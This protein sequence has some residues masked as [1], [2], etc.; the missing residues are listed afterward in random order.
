[1]TPTELDGLRIRLRDTLIDGE[2]WLRQIAAMDGAPEDWERTALDAAA[3]MLR[4]RTR[5]ASSLIKVAMLGAF[6]SGKSFLLSALQGGLE[7]VTVPD[8][9]G[10]P[11]EKFVGLLPSSPVPTTACPAT[12]VPVEPEDTA[13]DASQRGF[14]RVQ[15]TDSQ[16]DEWE[17]V[18]NS[19]APSVVAAYA[20]QDADPLE[21]LRQ[22]WDREVAEIEI[23]LSTYRLPAMLYDLPGAGSVN[24][25]HDTIIR[26]AMSKADCFI[27]VVHA[28]RSM[29]D[30]DL[31]LIRF[32]YAHHKISKK[33]VIWLVTAIDSATHLDHRNVRAWQA[34]VDRNNTYLKD[35]FTLD[36]RPDMGFINEGFIPVSP[37]SEARSIALEAQGNL[38]EARTK[39]AESRMDGLRA[40]LDDLISR[41]T[42]Q[43]HLARVAD[44]ASGL[45]D[46]RLNWL[47]DRLR[48]ERTPIEE[49]QGSL[50]A[51]ESELHKVRA[52]VP[53]LRTQL[54]E[55]LKEHTRRACRPFDRLAAHLHSVLDAQILATDVKRPTKANQVQLAKTQ[56]MQS[57]IEARPD[58][59]AALWERQEEHFKREIVRRVKEELGA[60]DRARQLH[61]HSFDIETLT[62]P[63]ARIERPAGRDLVQQTAALL[64]ISAP[65]VATG[66]WMA[67]MAAAGL[68]FPPA[69]AVL[70]LSMLVYMGVQRRRSRA[71]SLEVTQREWIA[72]LD[73]EA[74][75]V[76]ESFELS[77][78]LQGMDLIANLVERLESHQDELEG[79]MARLQ[80]RMAHPETQDQQALVDRLQAVVA[81]G[82]S[83]MAPLRA[84]GT[85]VGAAPRR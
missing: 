60:D 8:R 54:E 43:P 37:A 31:E 68:V 83:V 13:H 36:G 17:D 64:G 3:E 44:E 82:E 71:T 52:A 20:M 23:L 7:L 84:L 15:F 49:L 63:R 1:M 40:M 70:G 80:E 32:L 6:S 38:A 33:P 9:D 21:R 41:E 25:I 74:R 29:S 12:V 35:N 78:G 5:S 79:S 65:I 81:E 55:Q 10:I 76:R 72:A 69:I 77:I 2:S 67:G 39:A 46:H 19:P 47:S 66:S 22:H 16:D 11:A 4:L 30:D 85:A 14:L 50:S 24:A 58:G 75:E 27:Y 51:Q 61:G 48:M 26:Q 34:N 62:M 59:P 56:E 45:L 53:R 18:G 57:W 73:T 42:G 28:S